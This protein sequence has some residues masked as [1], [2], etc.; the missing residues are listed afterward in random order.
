MYWLSVTARA[1]LILM[2]AAPLAP[3]K[4]KKHTHPDGF[5]FELPSGWTAENGPDAVLLLPPGVK[6][7]PSREDNAEVYTVRASRV[8]A[9]DF[10]NSMRINL[11]RSGVKVAATDETFKGGQGM[12][13]MHIF[14][15]DHPERK[16]A[17]RIRLFTVLVK[18]WRLTLVG[19]GLREKVSGREGQLR[20]IAR[21]MEGR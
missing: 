20:E 11:E 3:A 13:T 21:S 10:V 16:V 12:G 1:A 18:G 8:E 6:V 2:L 7:D 4:G 17:Y 9:A 15:F 14:D 19:R 5:S